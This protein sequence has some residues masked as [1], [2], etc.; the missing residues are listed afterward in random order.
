VALVD[1]REVLPVARR[2]VDLLVETILDETAS[3]P[4]KSHHYSCDLDHYIRRLASST[5]A[6]SISTTPITASM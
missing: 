6:V 4:V 1:L 5:I 2:S 3:V